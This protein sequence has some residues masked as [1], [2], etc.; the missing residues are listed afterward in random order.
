[1]NP[2]SYICLIVALSISLTA[3][4]KKSTEGETPSPAK[5]EVFRNDVPFRTDKYLRIGYSIR[6]WEFAKEGLVLQEII[7]LDQN[8]KAELMKISKSEL[9]KIHKDP[10]PTTP[11]YRQ[12]LLCHLRRSNG[13]V[14]SVRLQQN[15]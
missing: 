15:T 12:M 1:M 2:T 11:W 10:L 8:T 5:L 4:C 7:V 13:Q 3:G 14:L 9:P 6:T